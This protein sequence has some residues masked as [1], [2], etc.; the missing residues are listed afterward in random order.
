MYVD[1]VIV[2]GTS[3]EGAKEFK[4]QMMK[5]FE[6]ID[7]GLLTCYLGIEVDQRKDCIMLK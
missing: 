4:Q 2:T 1:H 5:E 7:L 3:V 6:M